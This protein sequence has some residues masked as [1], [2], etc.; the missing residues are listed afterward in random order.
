MHI[1]LGGPSDCVGQHICRV[2]TSGIVHIKS[3]G[4]EQRARDAPRT[5][6]SATPAPRH[7]YGRSREARSAAPARLSAEPA[8]LAVSEGGFRRRVKLH[9][10]YA[11]KQG[12]AWKQ[13]PFQSG[14][15]KGREKKKKP[16]LRVPAYS[17]EAGVQP[18]GELVGCG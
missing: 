13:L 8:S 1:P 7:R 6:S 18:S 16:N 2:C 11:V 15:N 9:L 14:G 5:S 3:K 4:Q 12:L 17:G 10:H